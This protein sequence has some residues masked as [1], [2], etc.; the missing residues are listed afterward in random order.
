M[1]HGRRKW[2]GFPSQSSDNLL[3][4]LLEVRCIVHLGDVY[5]LIVSTIHKSLCPRK[6]KDKEVIDC[7]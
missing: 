7:I 3:F 2:Q 4:D 5:A 1:V 6:D